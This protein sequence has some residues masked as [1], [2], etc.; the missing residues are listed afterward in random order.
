MHPPTTEADFEEFFGSI[1]K[2]R[3]T[4][5]SSRDDTFNEEHLVSTEKGRRV[6]LGEIH[7]KS[8]N[9]TWHNALF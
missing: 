5:P 2:K 8:H 4:A 6:S 7:G 9:L 1:S 3:K